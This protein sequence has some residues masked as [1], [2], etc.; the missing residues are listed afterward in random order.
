LKKRCVKVAMKLISISRPMT[1]SMA[2]STVTGSSS[3]REWPAL[4]PGKKPLPWNEVTL[5][6]CAPNWLNGTPSAGPRWKYANANPAMVARYQ[7]TL[8][9]G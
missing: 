9:P 3:V 5:K 6:T 7:S 4:P 1:A 8:R 2:A